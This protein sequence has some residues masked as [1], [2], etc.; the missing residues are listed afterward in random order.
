[1]L[2]SEDCVKHLK[3][4]DCSPKPC[5]QRSEGSAESSGVRVQRPQPA[6]AETEVRQQE[7]EKKPPRGGLCAI[8]LRR[9]PASQLEGLKQKKEGWK[10]E[11]AGAAAAW[12][13]LK[14]A[15]G[16]FVLAACYCF[17]CRGLAVSCAVGCNAP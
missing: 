1:M 4:L 12:G 5:A 8:S 6:E 14:G 17:C 13:S 10:G 7:Q 15:V 2:A 3:R 16:D 9:S 11:G